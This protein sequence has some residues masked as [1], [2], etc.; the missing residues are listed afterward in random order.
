MKAKKFI[1][2]VC[3]L[4]MT[5]ASAATFV[6]AAGENV[7]IKGD[8]VSVAKGGD[9]FE[10]SFNLAQFAGEGFSGC[11]FAIEYDPAKITVDKVTEGASLKTGATEAE[12]EKSPTI[13]DEVTMVNKGSYNCFDYNIVEGD[14]KNTIAVLWCTG[15]DSSS[16]WASKEGALVTISGTVYEGA[17]EGEEIPVNIVAIDRDGNKDMVFGYVDGNADKVYTSAVSDQ[18]LITIKDEPVITDVLWG[19]VNDNGSVSASDLVAMM[20][21][22]LDSEAA[23]LTAQG[24]TNGNMDQTDGKTD[25]TDPLVLGSKDFLALKKYILGDYKVDI[26]PITK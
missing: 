26:F 10:L 5:A 19:D 25:L 3:A 6:S 18:G 17:K 12:L 23:N 13:G 21:F 7:I 22:M 16:Y 24:I 4:A 8:H 9:E 15:L 2:A 20:K 14:G 1:S 11:E